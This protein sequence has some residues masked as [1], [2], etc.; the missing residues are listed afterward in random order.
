MEGQISLESEVGQGTTVHLHLP[1]LIGSPAAL[2]AG[3]KSERLDPTPLQGQ[4]VLLVD[5]EI[6]N[7]E[8]AQYILDK[9]QMD[10]VAVEDGQAA[11]NR[12]EEDPAFALILMD[13]HM[14][15]ISGIEATQQIRQ[16]LGLTLP[17]LAM[18]ATA[19][20]A[21]LR[22]AQEAGM[23]G[24]LL[25]PFRE[26]ELLSIL[27]RLLDL[28]EVTGSPEAPPL[29]HA[30]S[31]PPA[32]AI[33]GP[34]APSTEYSLEAMYRLAHDNERFVKRML[35]LFVERSEEAL[36][37]L[38]A[39]AAQQ[40]WGQVGMSAHKLVPPCRHL[41]LHQLVDRLKHIERDV[42]ADQ[43]ISSERIEAVVADLTAVR[44]AIQADVAQ[45]DREG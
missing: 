41:G 29:S 16:R 15:R 1:L 35:T 3:E 4:R 11:L 17:I 38:Q 13:L 39:A 30:G 42:E 31:E 27:L 43:G 34:E 19:T 5:D 26:T 9:W 44:E 25:K 22:E 21:R 6:Y 45:L 8:L 10:V 7:R 32:L 36:Q 33:S 18:T 20:P 12:L 37:T 2:R 23:N 14:P 40:D 28:P 24:H